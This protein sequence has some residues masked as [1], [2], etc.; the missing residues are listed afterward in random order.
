MNMGLGVI[1]LGESRRKIHSTRLNP[2]SMV[3]ISQDCVERNLRRPK[4][5]LY[6]DLLVL[7][8]PF[9]SRLVFERGPDRPLLTRSRDVISTKYSFLFEIRNFIF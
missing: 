2:K 6:S 5:L 4:D 8:R 9:S 7:V 1:A 3:I